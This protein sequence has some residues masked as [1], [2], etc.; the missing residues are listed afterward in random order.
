MD[1]DPVVLVRSIILI[2]QSAVTKLGV[3]YY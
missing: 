3:K 1:G 2:S